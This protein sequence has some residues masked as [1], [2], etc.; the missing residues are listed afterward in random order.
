LEINLKELIA[1]GQP[2]HLVDSFELSAEVRRTYEQDVH[3]F[4]P[5]AV[6]LHA[7]YAA[8]VTEVTG[9]LKVQPSQSCSRCLKPIAETL[10]IP[11]RELFT[12]QPEAIRE[13]EDEM[14]HLITTDKIDLRPY[15]EEIVVVE[16]PL[17]PLC[18]TDC[19]GI[20]PVC[21]VNR[22]EEDCNCNT[23]SID[24]RL[25]GLADFFKK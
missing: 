7:R 6:D 1:G 22:N 20:C 10:T 15:L 24:P 8:G 16:I 2:I 3:A 14:Y 11:V 19:K 17:A 4:S 12:T 25:A 23:E 9:E 21:G 13:D 18:D 5:V